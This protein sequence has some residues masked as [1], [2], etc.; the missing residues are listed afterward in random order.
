MIIMVVARDGENNIGIDGGL[1][2][3]HLPN[4][5]KFFKKTT[6]RHNVVMGR[7]TYESIGRPL[8]HRKNFV[9][10]SDFMKFR[11]NHPKD[12]VIV[13]ENIEEIITYHKYIKEDF[14]I[15]GG[16]SLYEQFFPYAD[17]V[18]VSRIHGTF[19]GCDTKFPDPNDYGKWKESL[20]GFAPSDKDNKYAVS[21]LELVREE[22]NCRNN[23]THRFI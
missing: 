21:F 8:P 1:P 2:W 17:K 5:M 13:L 3:G 7:I 6:S 18:I 22:G 16:A 11:R 12:N 9:V 10:T 23:R 14:Y 4:D 15:I 19:E 20:I